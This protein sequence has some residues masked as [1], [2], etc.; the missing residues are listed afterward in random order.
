LRLRFKDARTWRYTINAIGKIIDEAAFRILEQGVRMKAIDPSRIVLVDF[1]MPR[2]SLD[3]YEF[4]KEETIGVNMDDLNKVLRRALKND[5]LLL[6]TLEGGR[7]AVS[8]MGR[9]KRTFIIPSLETIAEEVPE[10]KI[11]FKVHVKMQPSVF[12][13][14]VSELEPIGDAIEFIAKKDEEKLIAKATSELA[15]AEIELSVEN[16]AL[17]EFSSEEDEAR[18]LYTVDYLSDI[19]TA[20]QAAEELDFYFATA[21]PCKIEYTL[22]MGGSLVFYVAPR[23]E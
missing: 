23:V 21:V 16:G 15:E 9:G 14:V 19:S 11:P 3:E 22:P 17:I 6:E 7:L 18:A 10:L 5:E 13:D 20:S 4:A 12:R 1:N 2:E 8:F